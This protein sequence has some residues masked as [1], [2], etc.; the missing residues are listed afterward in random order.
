MRGA[1][2]QRRPRPED[3]WYYY[4]KAGKMNMK[5]ILSA[6]AGVLVILLQIITV[7]MEGSILNQEAQIKS[8]LTQLVQKVK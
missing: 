4:N 5:E 6:A 8:V 3:Y 1:R 7:I 2:R